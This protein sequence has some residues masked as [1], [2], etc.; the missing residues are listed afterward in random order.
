MIEIDGKEYRT[1][2]QW[3]KKKRAIL[4]RQRDKGRQ[5]KWHTGR[6]YATAVFYSEEQTR[7]YN[8]K[9]LAALKRKRKLMREAKKRQE[10]ARRQR[11]IMEEENRAMTAWKWLA[12]EKRVPKDDAVAEG[13]HPEWW[14][15]DLNS[16]CSDEKKWYR[17]RKKD[18]YEVE[19]S[20]YEV[21]KALYIKKFGGWEYIDLVHT[22]YDGKKWW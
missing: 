20:I 8:K 5:E 19:Q 16:W 4:K 17:Y 7:P 1:E 15:P 18:T 22:E 11:E 21:L 3:A 9:E 13:Y 14:E 2:V 10:E 6:K 12:Y